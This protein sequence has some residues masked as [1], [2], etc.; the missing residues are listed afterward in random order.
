MSWDIYLTEEVDQWL[1]ALART[2]SD[3]YLQTVL[4]IEVLEAEGPM[5]GRPLVDRVKG[6]RLHNLKELRPGSAGDSEIRIL[7]IFDPWRSA[8]L[9]IAGDKSGD[10]NRWYREH[11]PIAEQRYVEYLAQR[12]LEEGDTQ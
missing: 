10:W 1:H 11:V 6:S 4:A 9:L 8:A 3:S 5:L 12:Q 2:D 7:F